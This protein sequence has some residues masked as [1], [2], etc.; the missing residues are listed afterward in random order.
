MFRSSMRSSSG[1]FSFISL[2]MLLI[3]K[4]IKIFKNFKKYYQSVV[5]M[6]QRMFSVHVM[7][8]VWRRE[9]TCVYIVYWMSVVDTNPVIKVV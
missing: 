6:W 2:L 9:F 8:T 7:C 3:L 1:S 5:V 4:T